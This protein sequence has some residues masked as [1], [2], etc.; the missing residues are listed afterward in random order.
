[1]VEKMMQGRG[2]FDGDQSHST[3]MIDLERLPKDKQS[4]A[5]FFLKQR[6]E[7]W[8]AATHA[9][10]ALFKPVG[11]LLKWVNAKIYA[12]LASG[13]ITHGDF[14]VEAG[15][16]EEEQGQLMESLAD[17]VDDV[18]DL[19]QSK[20]GDA[21]E[22]FEAMCDALR[23]DGEDCEHLDLVLPALEGTT[24]RRKQQ[25][26]NEILEQIADLRDELGEG[27]LTTLK[28][29]VVKKGG[30][31]CKL[32]AV[33]GGQDELFEDAQIV[34]VP[35]DQVEGRVK[36][37]KA[38]ASLE[39]V[40]ADAFSDELDEALEARRQKKEAE[41]ALKVGKKNEQKWRGD[42]SRHLDGWQ[43]LAQPKFA[44]MRS[45]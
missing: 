44:N 1:M 2:L 38:V 3:D 6:E 24:T 29:F 40:Q 14:K 12:D 43:P 9:E 25:V 28:K 10:R 23:L 37:K 22:F 8:Q 35:A 13:G 15:E 33:C 26:F 18:E 21:N 41:K 39:I 45:I 11:N 34:E 19:I 42:Q 17:V 32:F 20:T 27:L 30:K 36:S 5:I 4:D 7:N 31:N 16:T